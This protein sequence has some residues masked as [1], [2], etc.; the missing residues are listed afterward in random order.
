[1]AWHKLPKHAATSL[2]KIGSCK[3]DRRNILLLLLEERTKPMYRPA[4]FH[5]WLCRS[6]V[7]CISTGSWHHSKLLNFCRVLSAC[8]VV[9]HAACLRK[10]T[11]T[12]FLPIYINRLPW[13]RVSM[14]SALILLT[15]THFLD[16]HGVFLLAETRD[17]ASSLNWK[18]SSTAE[19]NLR[20]RRDQNLKEV[21]TATALYGECLFTNLPGCFSRLTAHLHVLRQRSNVLTS[22]MRMQHA[23][24]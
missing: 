8:L 24:F 7:V 21:R 15:H 12:K 2:S 20:H 19:L 22:D 23:A 14:N 4:S 17:L 1:M 11:L 6:S 16:S 10:D 13:V 9:N 3:L 5:P 18:G